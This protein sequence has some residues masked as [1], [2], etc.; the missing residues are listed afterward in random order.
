M[1]L[2]YGW[3]LLE[4]CS[5][6]QTHCKTA[7]SPNLC[8]IFASQSATTSS[9]GSLNPN[10][11]SPDGSQAP[12]HLRSHYAV[13]GETNRNRYPRLALTMEQEIFRFQD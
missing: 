4:Q 3:K 7:D 12:V 6:H 10:A 2:A 9:R 11:D 8:V 1:Q 5:L 13:A